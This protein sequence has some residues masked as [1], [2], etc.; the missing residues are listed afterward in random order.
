MKEE[1][2]C[3]Y[4][5][6]WVVECV[7]RR[8][9]NKL[10]C[11][12]ARIMGVEIGRASTQYDSLIILLSSLYIHISFTARLGSFRGIENDLVNIFYVCANDD[13]LAHFAVSTLDTFITYPC[14]QMS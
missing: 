13:D 2:H 12:L 5:L 8:A 6:S 11:A 10:C 9:G 4:V 1:S 7:D 14:T 3:V